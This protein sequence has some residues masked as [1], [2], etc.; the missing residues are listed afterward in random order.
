[1]RN[2]K[3]RLFVVTLQFCTYSCEGWGHESQWLWSPVTPSMATRLL[4]GSCDCITEASQDSGYSFRA[5]LCMR[6]RTASSA[7]ASSAAGVGAVP[8]AACSK[9]CVWPCSRARPSSAIHTRA[10]AA[11]SVRARRRSWC[12]CRGLR[13][14]ARHGGGGMFVP[15][16]RWDSPTTARFETT[17]HAPT[18]RSAAASLPSPA[19]AA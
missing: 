12:Q 10:V 9:A 19:D 6:S 2:E 5:T 17:R 4:G 1:V 14:D 8:G 16:A 3:H 11:G 13:S 15:A 18:L 7:S